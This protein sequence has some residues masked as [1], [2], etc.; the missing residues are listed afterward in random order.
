M[1]RWASRLTLT[2]TDVR[3]ERLQ[4]ISEADAIAEG[5]DEPATQHFGDPVKAFSALWNSLGRTDETA[6][7]ANPWVSAV[8]FTVS[9]HN[10]DE[11]THA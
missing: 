4:D 1:P 9:K 5:M 3:V 7:D 11:V 10:I 2:V 6:W 8:S